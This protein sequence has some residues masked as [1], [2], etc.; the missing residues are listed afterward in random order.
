[1]YFTMV[2]IL[3]FMYTCS[4]MLKISDIKYGL[5]FKN[6]LTL[7]DKY[8]LYVTQKSGLFSVLFKT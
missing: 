7:S 4:L 1:M 5:Y 6:T 3:V 8:N 2:T